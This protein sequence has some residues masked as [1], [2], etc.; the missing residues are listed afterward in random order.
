M[1]NQYP[2]SFHG[3]RQLVTRQWLAMLLAWAGASRIER[4]GPLRRAGRALHTW[5]RIFAADAADRAPDAG[6]VDPEA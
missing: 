2:V 6:H 5:G 3:E 4:I 1:L